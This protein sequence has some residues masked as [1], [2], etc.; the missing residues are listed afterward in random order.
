MIF[1]ARIVKIRNLFLAELFSVNPLL[2]GRSNHYAVLWRR[3]TLY[4]LAIRQFVNCQR[5]VRFLINFI[6][7]KPKRVAWSMCFRLQRVNPLLFGAPPTT[8]RFYEERR[9]FAK[10]NVISA[11]E[12]IWQNRRSMYVSYNEQR[13]DQSGWH[14]RERNLRT[15]FIHP[16]S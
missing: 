15:S 3:A 11:G 12:G 13:Q 14:Q 6:A 7:V 2:F 16:S 10:R 5:H 9:L 8:T 1:L 4:S